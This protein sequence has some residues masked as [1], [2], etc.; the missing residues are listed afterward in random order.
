M[1]YEDLPT[2]IA[3]LTDQLILPEGIDLANYILSG[4]VP[5]SNPFFERSIRVT[6]AATI[7][8]GDYGK[9]I[10]HYDKIDL[11]ARP[12]LVIS[13]EFYSAISAKAELL[14]KVSEHLQVKVLLED[15][16]DGVLDHGAS[17]FTIAASNDSLLW[18]G[19]LSVSV[20]I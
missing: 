3:L 4:P 8:S 17:T 12:P 20:S 11:T 18:A 9:Y 13:P 10:V 15:I 14:V 2:A 16:V 6:W 7:D 5:E 1:V 19:V